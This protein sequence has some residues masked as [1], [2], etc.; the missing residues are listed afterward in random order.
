M[1]FKFGLKLTIAFFL[2]GTVILLVYYSTMSPMVALL[3]FQYTMLAMLVS[4][5]FAGFL[6]FK[7]LRRQ[8][9][10]SELLKTVAVMLVNIPVGIL[11]A[12]IMALLLKYAR[13]EIQNISELSITNI[14][15]K[16][17]EEKSMS[18]LE[19]G[20]HETA[21]IKLQDSCS[22]ILAYTINGEQRQ[23]TVLVDISPGYGVKVTHAIDQD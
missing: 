13:V 1:N 2:I 19:S 16:G 14:V 7:F 22:V 11:Y 21:W 12:Y 23:D 10:L 6:L 8:I 17:C 18:D 5:V 9:T 20:D 15:L 4:W 3:A